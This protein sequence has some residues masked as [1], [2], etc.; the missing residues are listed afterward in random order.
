MKAYIS[1][2]EYIIDKWDPEQHHFVVETHTLTIDIEDIYFLIRLSRRGRH[3]VLVDVI[4]TLECIH[5]YIYVLYPD[6]YSGKHL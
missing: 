4:V 1:L 6:I 2:L 5:F 3:M